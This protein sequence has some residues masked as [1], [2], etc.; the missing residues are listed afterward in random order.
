M[1]AWRRWLVGGL[2]AGMAGLPTVPA[3]A[4]GTTLTLT[5]RHSA[6]IDV[7]FN[8]DITLDLQQMVTTG[9][10]RFAGMYAE[11]ISVPVPQRQA[12]DRHAG[13]VRFRD[14]HEPGSP[15]FLFS[16]VARPSGTLK[17]GRYRL[18][19]LADGLTQVRVP[20]TGSRSLRLSPT[21]SAVTAIASD[22]DII[23]S[24]IEAKNV[25]P[26]VLTG[27]R[28]INMSALLV[29]EFR[30]FAGDIGTCLRRPETECGSATSSGVDGPFTSV[31]INPV[32]DYGL[33]W[34]ITYQSGVLTPG[35]YEAFQGAL[36]AA[37]LKYA[38][39]AAFSLT[40]T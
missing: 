4:A 20:M 7:T 24:A 33:A 40:L 39:G 1:N 23:V 18:Y 21:R 9:A 16:F 17:A 15:G 36:N 10:G 30:A 26:L 6:S 5:G 12:A 31:G 2:L 28:T 3:H 27:A 25:Q 32:E 38:S 29:G 22:A 14:V 37:G 35:R 13:A 19:L 11:A 8:A 34:S